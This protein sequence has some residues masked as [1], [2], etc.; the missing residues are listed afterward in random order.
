MNEESKC[1]V[2][3]VGSIKIQ[4]IAKAKQ[5]WLCSFKKHHKGN[6]SNKLIKVL[7][8]FYEKR[9]FVGWSKRR[10]ILE[11][12]MLYDAKVLKTLWK[13]KLRKFR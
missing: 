4:L 3:M 5:D 1:R 12:F 2:W 11:T 8:Y 9:C 10:K 6:K 7:G 13:S